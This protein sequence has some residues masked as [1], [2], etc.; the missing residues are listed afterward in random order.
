MTIGIRI[1]LA[2]LAAT[3][4]IIG[5]WNQFWPESFYND[6]PT[7]DLT[8][9][10][11]EHYAHDFGGATL[12][13]AVVLIAALI[14]PETKLVIVAATA[15]LVFAV[16]HYL[17]HLLHLEHAPTGDAVLLVTKL[18]ASVLIPV[19]VIALAVARMRCDTHLRDPAV[20]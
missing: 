19:F 11:S 14:W 1:G 20:G 17:F 6:F 4:L 16:P 8:P 13:L 2:F 7:V 3:Q 9:P 15:Y 10:F 18:G 5:G 12:G